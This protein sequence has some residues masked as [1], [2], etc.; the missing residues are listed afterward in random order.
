ML[1]IFNYLNGFLLKI[2]KV[3]CGADL[4]FKWFR[5]KLVG[6]TPK[7]GMDFSHEN[8]LTM[9]IRIENV[10]TDNVAGYWI[11]LVPRTGYQILDRFLI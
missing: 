9:T 1:I 6:L 5:N 2:L 3:I 7:R 10:M 8:C 4:T 11:I